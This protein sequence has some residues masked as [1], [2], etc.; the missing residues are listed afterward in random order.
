MLE[1]SKVITDS[2]LP[3]ATVKNRKILYFKGFPV[4]L[5]LAEFEKGSP[6][7]SLKGS[8]YRNH[9][10]YYELSPLCMMFQ[11]ETGL[12]VGEVVA[13]K[14]SDIETPNY[15]HIQRMLR[16]DEKRV[17][18]HTKTDYGDRPVPLT[19]FA[20]ELVEEARRRQKELNVSSEYIFSTD[21]NPIS[22]YCIQELYCKYCK[23]L[24]MGTEGH[25]KC[26]NSHTARRTY[27]SALIDG[28]VNLNTIR[29][30]V[31][32]ASE[33]TTLR[34]Y[35]FDRATEKE[36]LEKI[37]AAR[38]RL[39]PE[40]ADN[41]PGA[42]REQKLTRSRLSPHKN[43]HTNTCRNTSIPPCVCMSVFARLVAYA[44]KNTDPMALT[45]TKSV[46]SCA[47]RG[48]KKS[49]KRKHR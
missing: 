40:K 27:I 9:V 19:P 11:I 41:K 35:T 18:E 1:I 31:G 16:R 30:A 7:G 38:S 26:K 21:G 2:S 49:L 44:Q 32:H 25:P 29:L 17:V 39:S 28:G 5:L 14:F 46:L 12:R 42:P 47:F 36:K 22:A 33:K 45:S 6:G 15:I 23:R 24:G 10:K 48:S 43:R 37:E 34:N 8:S 4:L 3:S 13:V 20:K